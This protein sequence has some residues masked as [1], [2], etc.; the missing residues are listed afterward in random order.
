MTNFKLKLKLAA[1]FYCSQPLTLDALLSAAIYNA[2]GLQ[3]EETLEHI[4]LAREEGIFKGSSLFCMPTY[5]HIVV[6]RVM[7][8]RMENDLSENLFA[9]KGKRYTYI[10]PVRGD[11]QCNMSAYPGIES[12][13]VYFW[14]VGDPE[15]TA[16]LIR[17]FIPGI[18]KRCNG[19]AGEIDEVDWIELEDDYSWKTRT[20]RPARPLPLALWERLGGD[21]SA[22]VAPMAVTLPYWLN[23][24][25]VAVFP[26][27][28]VACR[29]GG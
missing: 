13:E 3:G 18:G 26:D 11:Y 8:L 21:P 12:R 23:E 17:N 14:G 7:S 16:H 20:G 19:G 24:K 2:T 25:V 27:S 28:K 1:P 29:A 15:R 22:P 9:P 5:R 6:G 4:P 10:D